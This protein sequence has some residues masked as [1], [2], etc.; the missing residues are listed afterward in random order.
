[1]NLE[2]RA[3]DFAA[4]YFAESVR[5]PWQIKQG[6]GL[7]TAN[8]AK[9]AKRDFKELHAR[10]LFPSVTKERPF[11]ICVRRDSLRMLGMSK[12]NGGKQSSNLICMRIISTRARHRAARLAF[13]L[14]ELLVVIAIIAILAALLLPVLSR[15]KAAADRT[16]CV[17]NL[18]QLGAAIAMYPFIPKHMAHGRVRNYLYFDWHVA[19]VKE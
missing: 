19:A 10:D 16:A 11:S 1:M 9:Y 4:F 6:E 5:V 13:T 17:N 2:T 7:V 14:I 18:K 12:D 8:H 3:E 15:A